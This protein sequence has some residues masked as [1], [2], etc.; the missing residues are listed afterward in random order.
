MKSKSAVV[1]VFL[2]LGLAS[3]SVLAD[4]ICKASM[5]G[6]VCYEEGSDEAIAAH[7]KGDAVAEASAKKKETQASAEDSL[8]GKKVVSK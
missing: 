7:M 3:T 1:F 6:R 5:M 4:K 8:S 2:A